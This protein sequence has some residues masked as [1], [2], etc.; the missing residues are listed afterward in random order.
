MG[1]A[2][3]VLV[4]VAG[5]VGS[6]GARVEGASPIGL[7]A[8]NSVVPVARTVSDMNSFHT[9]PGRSEPLIGRPEES[10]IGSLRSVPTHTAVAIWG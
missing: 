5:A 9:D 6:L 3:G 8:G 2:E 10:W 1:S 7:N 4:G